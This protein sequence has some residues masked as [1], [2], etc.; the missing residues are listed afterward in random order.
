MQSPGFQAV[1]YVFQY[2]L[3]NRPVVET[4][5]SQSCRCFIRRSLVRRHRIT[6]GKSEPPEQI[7]TFAWKKFPDFA[8]NCTAYPCDHEVGVVC[9]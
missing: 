8:R 7:G 2:E 4:E 6:F 1:L 9:L 3:H 5:R